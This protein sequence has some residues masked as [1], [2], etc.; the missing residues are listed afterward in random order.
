VATSN[1][2][3]GSISVTSTA[4]L[5]LTIWPGQS[6]TIQNVGS[7]A[8]YLGGPTVTTSGSTI[9]YSLANGTSITLPAPASQPQQ[10]YAIAAAAQTLVY[11][12]SHN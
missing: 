5:A 4:A 2:A 1:Y 3:N 6:V 7:A 12:V 9:G 10:L 11:L 8:V